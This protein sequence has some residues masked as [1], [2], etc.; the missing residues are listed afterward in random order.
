M[1]MMRFMKSDKLKQ[2]YKGLLLAGCLG[3]G[4]IPALAQPAT[5]LAQYQAKYPKEQIIGLQDPSLLAATP[6][7]RQCSE[8]AKRN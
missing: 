1:K 2:G 7:D 5:E 3:I 6:K 8:R 4:I